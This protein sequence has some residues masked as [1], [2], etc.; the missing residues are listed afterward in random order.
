MYSVRVYEIQD[1]WKTKNDDNNIEW[2]KHLYMCVRER[3]KVEGNQN[4]EKLNGRIL[5]QNTMTERER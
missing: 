2:D 5:M 4:R 3:K 1:S